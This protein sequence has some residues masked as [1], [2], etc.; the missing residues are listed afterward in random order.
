MEKVNPDIDANLNL[1][2]SPYG[3]GRE[4]ATNLNANLNS[5]PSGE[6]GRGLL[7]LTLEGRCGVIAFFEH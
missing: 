6:V 1:N 3:G 7:T 4:G 5:S 2:S